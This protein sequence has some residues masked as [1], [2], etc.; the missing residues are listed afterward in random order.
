MI[1]LS[2]LTGPQSGR[3]LGLTDLPCRCGKSGTLSAQFTGPGVWDEHFE[4]T[5]E[6]PGQIILRVLGDARICVDSVSVKEVKVRDG[7][8]LEVG[9]TRV[10]LG[11]VPAGHGSL[12]GREIVFWGSFALLMTAQAW[13]IWWIGR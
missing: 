12:V 10:R 13:S 6:A 3:R 8:I 11:I 1:E 7:L 4:I 9:A 5:V 2:I